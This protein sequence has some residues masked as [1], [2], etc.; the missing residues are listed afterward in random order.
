MHRCGGRSNPRQVFDGLD[1]I[2][3]GQRF[4]GR[5][6]LSDNIRDILS[7]LR[8]A[9]AAAIC[10]EVAPAF[11][12]SSCACAISICACAAAT[13]AC[14]ACTCCPDPFVASVNA[15]RA[16]FTA[17]FAALTRKRACSSG[18]PRPGHTSVF[19][20]PMSTVLKNSAATSLTICPGCWIAR[21]ALMD[22][23]R[24][25][26]RRKTARALSPIRRAVARH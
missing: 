10:V 17:S 24:P 4:D 23:L 13:F 21:S 7:D 6:Y 9:C 22:A 19:C 25:K 2:H 26:L 12:R 8:R 18:V 1:Q 20:P 11:K 3:P 5:G 14:A 15:E 16:A